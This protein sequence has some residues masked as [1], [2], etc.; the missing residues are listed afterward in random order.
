MDGSIDHHVALKR[1]GRGGGGR[2]EKAEC[3]GSGSARMAAFAGKYG[4]YHDDRKHGMTVV[5]PVCS[6]KW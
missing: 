1:G 2:G 5:Y 4:P 6:L 3:F